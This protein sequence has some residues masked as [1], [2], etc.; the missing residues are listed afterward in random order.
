MNS[1][2]KIH[3]LDNGQ[4]RDRINKTEKILFFLRS[5][6]ILL[7]AK[8]RSSNLLP[9]MKKT[10]QSANSSLGLSN[11]TVLFLKHSLLVQTNSRIKGLTAVIK[12]QSTFMYQTQFFSCC[13]DESFKN[14]TY[15]SQYPATLFNFEP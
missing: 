10:Q 13:R 9:K 1:T 15:T 12:K 6:A 11:T 5:L 3:L 4:E 8:Q 7:M 2:G 14:S